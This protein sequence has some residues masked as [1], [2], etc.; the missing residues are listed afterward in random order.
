MARALICQVCFREVAVA[1]VRCVD[2]LPAEERAAAKRKPENEVANALATFNSCRS[3]LDISSAPDPA[4][5][6]AL[7]EHDPE[8]ALAA[9]DASQRIT[10]LLRS[11]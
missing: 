1:G 5:L 8:A 6:L 2:C 7:A 10:Q 9:L 3:A 4:E 11:R